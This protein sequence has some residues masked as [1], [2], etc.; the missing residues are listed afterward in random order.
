MDWRGWLLENFA[1][2]IE[3]HPKRGYLYL[4]LAILSLAPHHCLTGTETSI[5]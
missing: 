1:G 3:Y 2:D 5:A 4:G